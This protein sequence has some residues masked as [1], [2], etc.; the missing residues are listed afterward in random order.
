MLCFWRVS[1]SK[2][3]FPHRLLRLQFADSL[4]CGNASSHLFLH[5]FLPRFFFFF[6][7]F[8]Q[9]LTLLRRIFSMSRKLTQNS[10]CFIFSFKCLVTSISL[11]IILLSDR[12]ICNWSTFRLQPSCLCIDT[13]QSPQVCSTSPPKTWSV[14][15]VVKFIENSELAEHAEM[16]RKHVSCYLLHCFF[17]LWEL[18]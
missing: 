7:S 2:E 10:K 14:S 17:N 15:E 12:N 18:F 9:H 16:F 1:G 5:L 13:S 3:I 4:Y 11:D 6:F 8:H